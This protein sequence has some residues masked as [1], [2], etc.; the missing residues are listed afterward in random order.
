MPRAAAKPRVA[1]SA[2]LL[3]VLLG[4]CLLLLNGSPGA[5]AHAERS[6]LQ[7][8]RVP[9]NCSAPGDSW[10][11]T[12]FNC[13]IPPSS[14]AT[15]MLG[16]P[17]AAPDTALCEVVNVEKP[18]IRTGLTCPVLDCTAVC[19]LVV[20]QNFFPSD[21]VFATTELLAA[22]KPSVPGC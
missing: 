7:E 22:W 13:S 9:T 4:M 12:A 21:L 10:G 20:M 3:P 11:R 16:A 17:P 6:L 15:C 18:N 5:E 8:A 14:S 1:A 19:D 2:D